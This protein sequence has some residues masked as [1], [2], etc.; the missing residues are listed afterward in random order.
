MV[1]TELSI[2]ADAACAP[3][4]RMGTLLRDAGKISPE[5]VERVARLQQ[6]QGLR[7]GEAAQRLGYVSEADVMQVL[8]RQ[9]DYPYLQ[10]G[11]GNCSP[12]LVAAFDPYGAQAETLRAVRSA[13]L[14]RWFGAAGKAL[15]VV[16]IARGDGASLFAANLAIVFAQLGKRTL[17]V[18]ANLRRPAQHVLFG[19]AAGRGLADILAGRADPGVVAGVPPFSG[20]SVLGAGTAPPN[21]QEL[22]SRP[23]FDTV[24]AQYAREHDIVLY[25]VADSTTGLDALLVAARTGGVLIVARKNKT[26]L[27]DVEALARQV[28]RNGACV[29]GSVLVDVP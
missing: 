14:L 23:A 11:E 4:T 9:F 19:L 20:L 27:G 5:H 18:D 17:L 8:A 15:A 16:G 10:A 2:N 12:Q 28:V 29:V 21:P 3:D 24:H 7:F 6:E 1:Q 25:D 26:H 13:L 22:L